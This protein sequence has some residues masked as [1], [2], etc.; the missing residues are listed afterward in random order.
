MSDHVDAKSKTIQDN[1]SITPQ[2]KA[3]SLKLVVSN[4]SPIQKKNPSQTLDPNTGFI[5]EV[6]KRSHCHY[7]LVARDPFHYLDCE[8]VLEIHD[9]EDEEELE[10]RAVVCHFPNILAEELN[11]FVEED[12]T[13]YGMILIQFQMKLLE[14]ILL[15]CRDHDALNLL[16]YVDDTSE[17]HA[18]GVY[19]SLVIY[20]DKVPTTTGTKT[21]MVIPTTQKTFDK[22]IDFMEQLNQNFRQTL[23]E[24]QRTNPSIRAYLKSNPCLKFFG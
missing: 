2:K 21:Q 9:N 11:E 23:W 12:E 19:R 1:S 18:F 6:R 8:I 3:P 22:W 15:F 17:G 16:I 5:A 20:E 14:Q 13:L 4:S 24:D 7:V 10:P